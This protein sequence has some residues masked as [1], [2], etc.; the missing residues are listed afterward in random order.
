MI[1][2][3]IIVDMAGEN[4]PRLRNH[5]S[6]GAEK[7]RR[8]KG[9]SSEAQGVFDRAV[10]LAEERN[11]QYV[12][13][14]FLA[15]AL[16]ERPEIR[17][18][19]AVNLDLPRFEEELATLTQPSTTVMLL[20]QTPSR[21]QMLR[22]RRMPPAEPAQPEMGATPA[23]AHLMMGITRYQK[24]TGLLEVETADLAVMLV[25]HHS[26]NVV[27]LIEELKVDKPALVASLR[28]VRRTEKDRTREQLSG[29]FNDQV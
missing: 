29:F 17:G 8:F 11:H 27:G 16:L 10:A 2:F 14:N 19:F 23:L 18:A 28:S 24:R 5:N 9:L 13:T 15:L 12:D 20:R 25:D 6:E 3:D 4:D 1:R 21:W 22:R 26:G 7:T